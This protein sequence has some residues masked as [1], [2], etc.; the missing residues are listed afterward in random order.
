MTRKIVEISRI[1]LLRLIL[2]STN[3]AILD[4]IRYW[5]WMSRLR[6]NGLVLVTRSAEIEQY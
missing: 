1:L 3:T 4:S 2:A 5:L 6:D